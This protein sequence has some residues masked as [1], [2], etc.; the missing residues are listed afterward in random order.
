[1]V[2]ELVSGQAM[3]RNRFPSLE[4]GIDVH[5]RISHNSDDMFGNERKIIIIVRNI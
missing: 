4:V 5:H 1:M 3:V 2:R